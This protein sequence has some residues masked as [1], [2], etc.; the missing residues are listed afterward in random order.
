MKR[1]QVTALLLCLILA[2]VL[3]V[4]SAFLIHEA[5]HECIGE[6]CEICARIAAAVHLMRSLAL[7][8]AILPAFFTALPAARK[9]HGFFRS[10]VGP[11]PTPVGWKVRLND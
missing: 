6:G 11:V 2:L 9:H 1:R 10:P 5:D 4:S 8:A 3:T 7:L